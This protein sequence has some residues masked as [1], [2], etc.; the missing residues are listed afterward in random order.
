[1]CIYA[2]V[3]SSRR[4]TDLLSNEE[5]GIEFNK[6]FRELTIFLN[7]HID[8]LTV[9]SSPDN[10]ESSLRVLG[11]MTRGKRMIFKSNENK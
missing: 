6:I 7:I 2:D 11:F 1:M 10:F 9:Y 3:V 4:T 5:G 8:K